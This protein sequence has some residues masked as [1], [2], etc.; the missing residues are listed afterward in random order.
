MF[1]PAA[2]YQ[3]TTRITRVEG[4]AFKTEGKV[5]VNPGWLTVYGKEAA[6]DEKDAMDGGAPQLVAVKQ[7]ETVSTEDIVVKSLADQNRRRA[8]TKPR[9]SPPWKA[10]ARWSTTRSLRAAMA[11]R[12]LGTRPPR[13]QIIEGLISEQ[14]IHRD[15]RELIPSAKAFSLITLLKGLASPR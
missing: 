4:E 15:G 1:Y 9:C 11:E 14:Y 2:E 12:G 3:I 8:S 13:A 10:R 6:N 7:G 5:L